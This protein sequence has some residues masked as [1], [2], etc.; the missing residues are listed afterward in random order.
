MLGEFRFFE[1]EVRLEPGCAG[2]DGTW[3]LSSLS[4]WFQGSFICCLDADSGGRPCLPETV[5]FP[6]SPWASLSRLLIHSLPRFSGRYY[7]RLIGLNALLRLTTSVD[8]G[9]GFFQLG[10]GS[11]FSVTTSV[12][13]ALGESLAASVLSLDLRPC[14]GAVQ[15]SFSLAVVVLI[16]LAGFTRLNGSVVAVI[17][18][19]H[20]SVYG[21]L[22]VCTG[23][24]LEHLL[25]KVL[26]TPTSLLRH[27]RH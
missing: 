20:C 21:N 5:L 25:G 27:V 3:S 4:L 1:S 12:E 24:A 16:F 18:A 9:S 10:F 19:R 26:G 8:T 14:L 13:A 17:S 6:A 2:G 23:W 15:N 22:E 7:L 11:R